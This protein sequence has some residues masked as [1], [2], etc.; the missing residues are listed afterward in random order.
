MPGRRSRKARATA[1]FDGERPIYEC[2]AVDVNTQSDFMTADGNLPIV[3]R[4]TVVER[5]KKLVDWAKTYRL[6]MVSLVDA[7]RPR[8][9][10]V[11]SPLFHCIEGTPGQ[12]KLP[13]TLLPKRY[14]I[15]HDCS[16]SLPEHLLD[17]YRQVIIRK[18]T[19]DP[20]TNPKA[21]RF[22]TRLQAKRLVI[23]G[24]GAERAIKAMALGLLSRGKCPILVSDACGCW[25]EQ[26]AELAVRQVEAKGAIVLDTDQLIQ[27]HPEDLPVAEIVIKADAE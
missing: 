26:A 17:D 21:D 27:V 1:V 20:F 23:F 14:V 8:G 5:I 9:Q 19:N 22:F 10:S 15:D 6:P 2:I 11:R 7:H 24:V 4:Q 16:P 12:Q 13:F 3:D 18:R 25:D